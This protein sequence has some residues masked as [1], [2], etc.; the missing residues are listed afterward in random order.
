MVEHPGAVVRSFFEA[1][2]ARDWSAA[3][4][5]LSPSIRIDFTETGERFDGPNFL[6]MNEAYPEGWAIEVIETVCQGNRVA[7]QIKVSH[8]DVVFWCGGFYSVADGVITSGV[9]HWLT[10]RAHPAPEW[11]VPYATTETE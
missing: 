5:R 9:E 2:E 10:E 3:G 4:E 6:A 1:M 8:E 11:R 7:A